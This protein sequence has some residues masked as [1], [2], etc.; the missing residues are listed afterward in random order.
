MASREF[1]RC[2]LSGDGDAAILQA[3]LVFSMMTNASDATNFFYDASEHDD[4][5]DELN[6]I[7]RVR[8]LLIVD[9]RLLIANH[10]LWNKGFSINNQESTIAVLV[11]ISQ[12][13]LDSEV[14]VEA[15]EADSLD[16]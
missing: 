5:Q 2:A 4:L 6:M 3:A 12:V 7:V 11:R 9:F 14:F 10:R 8:E 16:F 1:F 15:V 13:A